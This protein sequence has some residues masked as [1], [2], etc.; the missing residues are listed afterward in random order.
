MR[1]ASREAARDGGRLSA[2][3]AAVERR[4]RYESAVGVA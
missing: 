3:A 4:P 2:K 1:T